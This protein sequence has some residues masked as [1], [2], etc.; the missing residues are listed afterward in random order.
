MPLKQLIPYFISGDQ[1]FYSDLPATLDLTGVFCNDF[2][3]LCVEVCR[4][5][6][7]PLKFKLEGVPNENSLIGCVD[8]ICKGKTLYL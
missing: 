3:F 2:N 6:T 5:P 8:V 4:A 7:S 1:A